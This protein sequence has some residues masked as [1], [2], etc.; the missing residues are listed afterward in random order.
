MTDAGLGP[1]GIDELL[2]RTRESLAMMRG[3]RPDSP[4]GPDEAREIRGTAES[5]DGMIRATVAPGSRL[6]SVALDPRA[7]RMASESLAEE[8]TRTVNAAFA[9]LRER[10]AEAGSGVGAPDAEALAGQLRDLQDESVRRMAAFGQA[11]NEVLARLGGRGTAG[12]G[13]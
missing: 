2:R 5:A 3:D 13:G 6:E 8:I 1:A 11:M 7:M 12:S 4:E 10:A 9:D